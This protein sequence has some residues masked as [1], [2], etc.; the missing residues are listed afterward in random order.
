MLA[1]LG[2]T[3]VASLSGGALVKG[4]TAGGLG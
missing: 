3:F 2:I 4:L 1:L